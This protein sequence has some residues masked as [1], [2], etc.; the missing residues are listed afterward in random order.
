MNDMKELKEM[1]HKHF[2]D[3]T[4]RFGDL[5]ETLKNINSKINLNPED[6]EKMEAEFDLRIEKSMK[7]VL[8]GTGKWSY[9]AL[10]VGAG[11]IGALIIIF[12]GFKTLLA[13][14]GFTVMK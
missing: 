14:L 9:Q 3:D 7:K 10:L 5:K 2:E 13:W 1:L 8:Y 4:E 6:K 11:I 12:G